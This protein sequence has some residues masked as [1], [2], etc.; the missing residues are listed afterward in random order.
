MATALPIPDDCARCRS[1]AESTLSKKPMHRKFLRAS[2]AEL[3]P[4]EHREAE[5]YLAFLDA[6]GWSG[7]RIAEAYLTIVDDTFQEELFFRETGKYRCS[8]YREA[9]ERVYDNPGYMERYMI[10]LGLTSFWWINHVL[11]KRFFEASLP[12]LAGGSYLEVGPGHGIYFLAALDSGLFSR[13]RAIDI[14]QTSVDL[15][16]RLVG[17]G[18]FGNHSGN[19]VERMDFFDMSPDAAIDTLVMGEVLEHVEDPAAFLR[20]AHEVAAPAAKLFLTTCINSPAVDHIYNPES[21][22]NL[23]RLVEN[24][25]FRLADSLLAPRMGKT[26]DECEKE[27]LAVN[28]AMVLEKT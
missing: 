12:A 14:S 17:G 24:Q 1:I 19:L 10:G 4:A 18:F 15:T 2:M 23:K 22:A 8:S 16:N 13:C 21:F 28:V 25:G 3:T 7:E 20:K 26:L 11:M 5:R 6:E 27:K 9:A